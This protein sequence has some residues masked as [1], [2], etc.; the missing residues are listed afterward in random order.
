MY[1]ISYS[2]F[3]SSTIF[4]ITLKSQ[5]FRTYG[6]LKSACNMGLLPQ[7]RTDQ[8][9][10]EYVDIGFALSSI[11]GSTLKDTLNKMARTMKKRNMASKRYWVASEGYK[12]RN[13]TTRSR[14]F[15]QTAML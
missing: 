13:G 12:V 10:L 6:T 8:T 11:L 4:E 2:I 3:Q 14:T 7:P 15:R 5:L 9:R 1:F